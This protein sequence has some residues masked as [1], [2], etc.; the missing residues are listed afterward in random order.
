MR[1]LRANVGSRNEETR[2]DLV[3]D[4]EIPGV[5]DRSLQ[6]GIDWQEALRRKGGGRWAFRIEIVREGVSASE[7]RV[8]VVEGERAG[9]GERLNY[10]ETEWRNR[11]RVFVNIHP[12][13]IV[14]VAC[15]GANDGL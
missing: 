8:R 10:G 15:T 13:V 11:R 14:R 9:S 5:L 7:V 3:L 4:S 1:D 6:V 12:D 2:R